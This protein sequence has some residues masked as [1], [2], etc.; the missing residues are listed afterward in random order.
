MSFQTQARVSV[1][2]PS[3]TVFTSSITASV[4]STRP[5]LFYGAVVTNPSTTLVATV[6]I[7]SIGAP[8]VSGSII[9]M[10]IAPLR[11]TVSIIQP[12]GVGFATLGVSVLGTAI[13][14]I[15]YI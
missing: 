6:S 4:I 9:A 2:K 12:Q 10:I 15:H 5:G 3:S 8:A 13:Y 1:L 14:S 7:L 11:T